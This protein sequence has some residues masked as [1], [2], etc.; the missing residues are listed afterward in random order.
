MMNRTS[1]PVPPSLAR[2]LVTLA[3]LLLVVGVAAGYQAGSTRVTL[4][5][6]GVPRSL[7]THQATV[8]ALLL[9]AGVVLH[10]EDIVEP[11]PD[12]PLSPGMTVRVVH[13]RSVWIEA[14]GRRWQIRT[15]ATI[16]EQILQEAGVPLGPHDEVRVE[17]DDSALHLLV[18][19]AIPVTLHEDGE[20]FTF[21]T[22]ARTVGEAL[23][24]AGLTLYLADRVRP[25]LGEP[26]TAGTHIYVE[27][28]RPVTVR[29]DGRTIRT[30]T[31]RER[32]GEVL[33]DLGIVLSGQ[34]YTRPPLDA[35]LGDETTI[36]VVRVAEEFVVE[37]SP[38]PFDVVWQPDPD[39]EID[40]RR[41]LQEGAPGTLKRRWRVRYE[42]GVEVSRTLE[43]EYVAVPPTTKII[44]Y[45]TKIVVRQ[46][47]T[48]Q[49]VV[50]YWRVIRMLAPSYSASTAGVP[51]TSPYYGRTRLG[52]PMRRGIVAVDPRL[53]PL[54]SRV[55][56][57]GYGVGLAAD[58]GGAIRGRRI[59]LGYDDDNL[60]LWYRWVDVYLLTPVPP[61]EQIDYILEQ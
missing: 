58:T 25:D 52:L 31:H 19:R 14:D 12:T 37:Q 22:T 53:I 1:R 7:R 28:S 20:T 42:N 38:I 35:S 40:H 13:A 6:D 2:G 9:D 15:H 48:P 59:D 36:E 5:V 3:A 8:G 10:P 27:R 34:D 4:V 23:R 41:V 51:Q 33:A 32:V 57:P 18:R 50:E 49:G 61:P 54:G 21:H 26:L 43:N 17:A 56:V 39:L 55:Y 44:G 47:K 30:R 24:E 46:L 45:G 29:V 60:V 16:P 11:S